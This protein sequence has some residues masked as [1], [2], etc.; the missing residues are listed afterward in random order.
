MKDS[1]IPSVSEQKL[2]VYSMDP[3]RFKSLT[4]KARIGERYG[5][6]SN[7]RING[8]V[9]FNHVFCPDGDKPVRIETL[10]R[11]RELEG[12]VEL[13]SFIQLT[14]ALALNKGELEIAQMAQVLEDT[15]VFIGEDEANFGIELIKQR[16]Q[17]EVSGGKKVWVSGEGFRSERYFSLLLMRAL[18]KD[19][20]TME[21]VRYLNREDKIGEEVSVSLRNGD[22]VKV[23]KVD[24][25]CLSGV[26]AVGMLSGLGNSLIEADIPEGKIGNIVEY[27]SLAM[28]TYKNEGIKTYYGEVPV[29]SVFGVPP[30]VDVNGTRYSQGITGSHCSTDYGFSDVIGRM[31]EFLQEKCWLTIKMPTLSK[32]VPP[33]ENVENSGRFRDQ[34]LQ[35]EFEYYVSKYGRGVE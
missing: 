4:E 8:E 33:Y 15:L 19:G 31:G 16:L 24:D 25:F 6:R 35:E 3:P 13:S 34:Y 30:F 26:Q 29:F 10:E 7:P 18:H 28:K 5:D 14:K 1:E 23:V 17:K 32:I 27:N 11:N 20:L 2:T 9:G 21:N 22:K 12:V